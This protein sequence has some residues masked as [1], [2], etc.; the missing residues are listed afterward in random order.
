MR[1][2][3]TTQGVL[4]AAQLQFGDR[5]S[6]TTKYKKN[7]YKQDNTNSKLNAFSLVV[8]ISQKNT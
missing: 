4:T 6:M 5:K 2:V 3:T 7:I 8:K 1:K